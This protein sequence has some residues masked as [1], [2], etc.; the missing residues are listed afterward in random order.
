M[1]VVGGFCDNYI[2]ITRDWVGSKFSKIVCDEI[3]AG[4]LMLQFAADLI[5]GAERCSYTWCVQKR[6]S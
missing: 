4:I 6:T 5:I 2:R 1:L 3:A